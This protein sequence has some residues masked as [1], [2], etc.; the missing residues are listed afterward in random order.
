M[1]AVKN[2]IWKEDIPVQKITINSAENLT[3]RLSQLR[4]QESGK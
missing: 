2:S 1:L 3:D 4:A